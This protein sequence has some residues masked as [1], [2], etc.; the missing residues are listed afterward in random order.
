M[1]EQIFITVTIV[2][3]ISLVPIII[4]QFILKAHWKIYWLLLVLMLPG[5]AIIN[6]GLKNW[7]FLGLNRWDPS[8]FGRGG[9]RAITYSD[10]RT[11]HCAS[12]ASGKSNQ[13]PFDAIWEG[14]LF[15]E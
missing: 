3:V 8:S 4:V 15:G 5:S 1:N 7:I 12:H 2:T 14:G 9:A 6:L 11:A 13:V 10:A